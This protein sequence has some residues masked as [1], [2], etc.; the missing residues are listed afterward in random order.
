MCIYIDEKAVVVR[1]PDVVAW[2]THL[3]LEVWSRGM[4]CRA[5]TLTVVVRSPDV[6]AHSPEAGVVVTWNVL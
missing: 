1:S 3:K 5:T 4:Y 2:P 6:L